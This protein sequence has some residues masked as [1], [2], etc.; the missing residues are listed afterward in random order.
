FFERRGIH[1][2]EVFLLE[3]VREVPRQQM[4]IHLGKDVVLV[5][6]LHDTQWRFARAKSRNAGALCELPRDRGDFSRDDL[7]GNL[8]LETFLYVAD[9]GQFCFHFWCFYDGARGVSSAK[10]GTRTLKGCPTGS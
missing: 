8:D 6:V 1:Q 7:F 10:G 5:S 4:L 9:I 2:V 3:R